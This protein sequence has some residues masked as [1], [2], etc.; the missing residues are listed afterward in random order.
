MKMHSLLKSPENPMLTPNRSAPP[1]SVKQQKLHNS[2]RGKKNHIVLKCKEV[3]S[4]S[5]LKY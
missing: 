5:S 1:N 4:L 2:S 3:F